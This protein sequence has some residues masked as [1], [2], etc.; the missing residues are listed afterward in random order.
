MR[1]A[2]CSSEIAEHKR[3]FLDAANAD[4][5]GGRHSTG[6]RWW[7]VFCVHGRGVSPIPD[8]RDASRVARLEVEDLLEDYAVWLAMYRP[9]GRQVAHKSI[10]KYCSSVRAWYKRFYRA[11]LGLG[12]REGR[13]PDILKGY[14]RLVDQPP[15]RER[16]GCAPAALA[17]GMRGAFGGESGEH[18][19]WRAAL[20][21]GFGAMA[22][23]IEFA[24][25]AERGETFEVSEHMVPADVQFFERGGARHSRVRMRKRKDLQVLRGKHAEVVLAGGG[26]AFDAALLLEQWLIRRRELG[27]GEGRPLFCHEDGSGITV[28][29]VR[30]AVRAAMSAAGLDPELY[31]AH[32]L[33]I[34]AAT[35][36]LAA[37]VA[38]GLI[39]LMGRWSSDV[40]ELY[41]RMSLEAALSV[42]RAMAAATVTTFE[43]GFREE[44]LELQP[45]EVAVMRE[46]ADAAL[47]VESEEDD[48]EE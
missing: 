48:G 20:G 9:S 23:G 28:R 1:S 44:H 31:G 47:D 2:A 4:R 41:C 12:A 42:G 29:E 3:R 27:I 5:R 17:R 22:R 13:I 15:P 35:A 34:G 43:G 40:Y 37:G 45:S 39:R 6:V 14:A 32:S 24:L 18:Y 16:H 26:A 19:M 30:A 10:E 11:T 25:D 8:P 7:F 46:A 38:P 36:A 21:F 33:R